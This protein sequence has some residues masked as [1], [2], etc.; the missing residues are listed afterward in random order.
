M[1]YASH[2]EDYYRV[3]VSLQIFHAELFAK[4]FSWTVCNWTGAQQKE[5][6]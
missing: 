2:S 6:Y 5:S 3:D 1:D 4:L